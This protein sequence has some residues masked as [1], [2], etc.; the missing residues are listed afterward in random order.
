MRTIGF[1]RAISV[2]SSPL[3]ELT[4]GET[5]IPSINAFP[6]RRSAHSRSRSESFSEAR[7]IGT[8]F[9]SNCSKARK[10]FMEITN[11]LSP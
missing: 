3:P 11:S 5:K 7:I 10:R 6:A 2:K 8:A 4:Q 1:L 9:A